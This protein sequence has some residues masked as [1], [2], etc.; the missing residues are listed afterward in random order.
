MS[1]RKS[2]AA[3]VNEPR[4]TTTAITVGAA[5]A[6]PEASAPDAQPSLIDT[7]ATRRAIRASARTTSLS[8]Q[9]A[10]SRDEPARQSAADR[11]IHGVKD[12]GK[13]DCTKGGYAGAGMGLLSRPFLAAAL[14][15][16][17]AK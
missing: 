9:L 16:K 12:A 2:A 11:L 14:S 7:E 17:C 1:A 15:G 3:R 10:H 6:P 5:I 8:D 13:A 4:E